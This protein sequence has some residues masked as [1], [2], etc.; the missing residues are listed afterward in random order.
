MLYFKKQLPVGKYHKLEKNTILNWA[1]ANQP[2]ISYRDQHE[3]G[4]LSAVAQCIF[5]IQKFSSAP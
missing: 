5:L 2:H 3:K 1:V 4:H